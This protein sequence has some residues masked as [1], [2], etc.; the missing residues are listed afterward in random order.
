M[1]GEAAEGAGSSSPP[2]EVG[3]GDAEEETSSVLEDFLGLAVDE[4]PAAK[5]SPA[6]AAAV[7]VAQQKAK[8]HVRS[9]RAAR[10]SR[11]GL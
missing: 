3:L 1:V 4:G 6:G 11:L 8:E 5:P 2:L 9:F 7:E 10:R